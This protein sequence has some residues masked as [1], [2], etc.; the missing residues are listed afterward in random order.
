MKDL[1]LRSV[2]DAGWS[3]V[4][5]CSYCAA[6]LES[7]EHGLVC[8]AE[9]RWFAT[10]RGVHRLLPQDRREELLLG[11]ELQS[12]ALRDEP[13]QAT[14]RE[15]AEA[16]LAQALNLARS[17]LPSSAWRVLDVGAGSCWASARLAREGHA[18]LAIDVSMDTEQ[19]LP[20]ASAATLARA[21][22]EMDALPLD[23]GLFDLVLCIASLHYAPRLARALSELRRVTRRGGLLLGLGSPLFRRREDGE[24][25]VA[26]QMRRLSKRYGFA[27]ERELVPG[28]LV[29]GEAAEA[30]R[31]TGWKLEV[32][33][34][35]RRAAEWFEDASLR[36]VGRRPAARL[37]L[38]LARRD[39]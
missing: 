20:A 4:W 10:D 23:P 36:L 3:T 5:R 11:S 34:W 19:G 14:S 18:V 6:P 33:G 9:G 29:L 17:S 15:H 12:R 38:L 35:P 8:S 26:G 24:A 22:A 7:H 37:P 16:E 31:D 1:A 39:A 32:V 25:T 27:V 28:Y 2:V 30:F 21:E 13:R